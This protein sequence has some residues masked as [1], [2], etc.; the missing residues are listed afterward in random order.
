[1]AA[2]LAPPAAAGG[3]GRAAGIVVGVGPKDPEDP[4]RVDLLGVFSFSSLPLEVPDEALA[5]P[6]VKGMTLEMELFLEDFFSLDPLVLEEALSSSLD[7]LE[8]TDTCVTRSTLTTARSS[9]PSD[10]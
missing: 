6:I 10:S 7:F 4:L 8:G 1:M 2:I 3:A 5:L 9:K